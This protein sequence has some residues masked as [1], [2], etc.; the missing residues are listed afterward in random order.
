MYI[1]CHGH[2]ALVSSPDPVNWFTLRVRVRVHWWLFADEGVE[3]V[4]ASLPG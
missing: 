4:G 1:G 2:R 3:A